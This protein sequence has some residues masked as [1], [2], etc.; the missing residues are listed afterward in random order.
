MLPYKIYR[1]KSLASTQDKAKELARKG[2]SN[3]VVVADVQTKGRGRFKRKWFSGK[4]GLWMSI[5]LRPKSAE[6][7]QYL[8]FAAA[9]AVAESIK[10]TAKLKVC[11]KWPNDVHYKG[12]KLCGIL[13]EGVFGKENYAVVGFGL[14]INQDKFAEEIKYTATSLRIIKNKIIDIKKLT[15][16][17]I[18]EFFKIY[19]NLYNK[20]KLNNI[21]K[22]W[23][24]YCDTI[25]RKVVVI[26][27]NRKIC[28]KAIGID[29]DCSL[30]LKLK[31]SRIARIIEGDIKIRY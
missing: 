29:N 11:I 8:T 23:K 7:L 16:N 10:K 6:K 3:L 15:E 12:K 2:L 18:H 20:N 24:K 26:S 9:V 4:G 28:G 14:N 31:N 17:T 30:I 19:D 22:I 5:L 1:F 21:Q 27:R 25:N 13:T